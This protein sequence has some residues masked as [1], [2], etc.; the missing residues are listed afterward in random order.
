MQCFSYVYGCQIYKIPKF[1][2]ICKSMLALADQQHSCLSWRRVSNHVARFAT[3]EDP[4]GWNVLQFNN[5]SY[6][7]AHY[8]SFWTCCSH[9]PLSDQHSRWINIKSH[10]WE[11]Q[12]QKGSALCNLA[13]FANWVGNSP[14]YR[15]LHPFVSLHKAYMSKRQSHSPMFTCMHAWPAQGC[16]GR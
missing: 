13:I 12:N 10:N 3:D 15:S 7:I 11:D 8:S 6:L 4:H 16:Q 1:F 14:L 5:F 2:D 9:E